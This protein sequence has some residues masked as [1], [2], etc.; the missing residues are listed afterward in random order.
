MRPRELALLILLSAPLSA[1]GQDRLE[2]PRVFVG[3]TAGPMRV[4]LAELAPR[5]KPAWRDDVLHDAMR[6]LVQGDRD[7][8]DRAVARIQIAGSTDYQELTFWLPYHAIAYDWLQGFD[9]FSP[10]ERAKARDALLVG[11][12]ACAPLYLEEGRQIFHNSYPGNACPAALAAMVLSPESS[13]A[14]ETWEKAHEKILAELLPGL[15]YRDGAFQEG[16]S[17]AMELYEPLLLYLAAYESWTGEDIFRKIEREFGDC[18]RSGLLWMVYGARGGRTFVRW[19]DI[20]G[21]SRATTREERK[22]MFDLVAFATSDADLAA[23]SRRLSEIWKDG[24]HGATRNALWSY[25]WERPELAGRATRQLPPDRLWGKD[26]LGHAILRAGWEDG[27]T[28]VSFQAGDHFGFH[29]HQDQG[30]FTIWRGEPLAAEGGLYSLEKP[31]YDRYFTTAWAHNLVV[32]SGPG[33]A[34]DGAQRPLHLHHCFSVEEYRTLLSNDSLE[35]GNILYFESRPD[36]AAVGADITAAYDPVSMSGFVRQ[37]VF[38]RPATVV[39]LDSVA[40]AKGDQIPRWLLQTVE[41]PEI[42]ENGAVL[43]KG[44]TRLYVRRLLPEN[45]EARVVEGFVAAGETYTPGRGPQEFD[46]NARWRIELSPGSGGRVFFLH[47]L[48]AAAPGGTPPAARLA[49]DGSSL[50]ATVGGRTVLFD[51]SGR[52]APRVR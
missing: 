31:Y 34:H 30:N 5:A 35:T 51:P 48:F 26:S 9:G 25:L 41:K 47:V 36:H 23:F 8:A 10:Q 19:G 12:R 33:V 40:T 17:Y 14:K 4:A 37:L 27:D 29:Q 6:W 18:V 46:E 11:I 52:R 21:G 44:E 45:A 39:V 16:Y 50:G 38:L 15:A 28:V 42:V 24:V 7:A 20:V 49:R 13:E 3:R 1:L 2:R 43:T 32:L 22:W